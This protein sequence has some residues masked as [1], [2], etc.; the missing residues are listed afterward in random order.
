[1]LRY[2]SAR[3][4]SFAEYWKHFMVHLNGVHAFRYNFAGSELIWMKFGALLVHCLP[5]SLADFGRD[6]CRSES[7]RVSRIF[8]CFCEVN[9]ARFAV[10]QISRNL[11]TRRGSVSRWILLERNFENLSAR[12]LF[13]PKRQLLVENLQRLWTSGRYISEIITNR[14]NSRPIGPSKECWLS[15]C[16]IGINSRSFPWTADSVHGRTF[17]DT[18]LLNG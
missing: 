7:E 11:H 13:S 12:G 16:T 5:L 15:I 1:M 17:I 10:G 6:L 4:Y 18:S 3:S 9:N 14:G 2:Y 8:V